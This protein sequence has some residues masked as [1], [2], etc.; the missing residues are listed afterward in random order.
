ME[1]HILIIIGLKAQTEH[2]NQN[3]QAASVAEGSFKPFS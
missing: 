1:L 3:K 2:I